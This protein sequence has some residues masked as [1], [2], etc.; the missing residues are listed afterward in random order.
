MGPLH[1]ESGV[2][3]ISLCL[4]LLIVYLRLSKK[5]SP[6]SS[7]T[8]FLACYKIN[9]HTNTITMHVPTGDKKQGKPTLSS[10]WNFFGI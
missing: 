4:T 1:W 6:M 10:Q 7:K 2:L 5:L 3:A 8:N 9:V